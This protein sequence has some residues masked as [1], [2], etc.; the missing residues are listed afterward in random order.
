MRKRRIVAFR[1]PHG[2]S[3][4]G[5]SIPSDPKREKARLPIPS[6]CL[7]VDTREKLSCERIRVTNRPSYKTEKG[8]WKTE[9]GELYIY[10]IAK[11]ID[12]LDVEI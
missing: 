12:A 11:R 6:S 3:S 7:G 9:T 2:H 4:S 10:M 1:L 5:I 8:G